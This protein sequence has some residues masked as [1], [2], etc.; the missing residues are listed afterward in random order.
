MVLPSGRSATKVLWTW[1][2]ARGPLKVGDKRREADDGG[3]N[4]ATAVQ[5]SDRRRRGGAAGAGA[6]AAAAEQRAATRERDARFANVAQALFR[7]F[8]QAAGE[9]RP[10]RGRRLRRQ[11]VPV[12]RVAQH[13]RQRI[14]HVV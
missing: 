1:A 6:T 14:R 8:V 12:R 10:H 9:E 5:M 3:R 13:R 2:A 4:S 7:V 11:G